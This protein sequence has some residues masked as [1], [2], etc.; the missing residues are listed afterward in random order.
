MASGKARQR[1]M[2]YLAVLLALTVVGLLIP[3][4]QQIWH[5]SAQRDKETELLF[6]GHQFR[7]ALASYRDRSPPGSPTTPAS[8]EELL[9]DPRFPQTVRH[10]RRLWTDPMTQ[11]ADWVL[12]RQ[13]GRIVGVHSRSEQL[14]RRTAHTAPHDAFAGTTRY[15]QWVFTA[16]DTPAAKPTP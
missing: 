9:Q 12:L 11:Q 8:L 15:D 4:A 14:V 7:L 6:V 1:G 3:G 13:Q 2:G 5:S 16:L 10:L